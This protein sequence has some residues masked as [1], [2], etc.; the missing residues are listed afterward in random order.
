MLLVGAIAIYLGDFIMRARSITVTAYFETVQGLPAGAEV[1]FAGVKIGRVTAVTLGDNPDFPKQ[2]AAVRMAIY[3]DA[4]VY[5]NDNFVIQQGALLGDKY[6]EVQRTDLK[7]GQQRTQ[8]QNNGTIAGGESQGIEQL[9]EQA[10]ALVTEA[11]SALAAMQAVFITDFNV[12]AMKSIITNVLGATAKADL[13]ATQAMRLTEMLTRQ[14]QQSTPDV[15]RLLS[16]FARASE[17]VASTSEMVR[18]FLV[19]S[20]V[21][22][23]VTIASGNMRQISQDM[24]KISDNMVQL[25]G[26]PEARGKLQMALDNLAESSGHLAKISAEA[27]KLLTD[28]S[29]SEDVRAALCSLRQA[30]ANIASISDTYQKLLTDPGFT[31]DLRG[32]MTA[33]RQ[34]AEAGARTLE[35]ADT[36]L[37]R[38]ERSMA[39]IS[40]AAQSIVPSRVTARASIEST[41]RTIFDADVQY[42]RDPN[43][44]WRIGIRD[45]GHENRLD[46]QRSEP[47]GKRDRVRAGFF[48]GQLGVGYDYAPGQPFNVETELW[49]PRDLHLDVRGAYEFHPQTEV[50]FGVSDVTDEADPFVGV[51]YR[52]SGGR[53]AP[54]DA[55]RPEPKEPAATGGGN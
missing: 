2:P 43:R 42:G 44:F 4:T 34:A 25:L 1:R 26:T 38:I 30:A 10:K 27:E 16:N 32:T 18:K 49:D 55:R 17:S 15:Q 46:L 53:S 33:A 40:G 37:A 14:V 54:R 24:T 21:P 36:Q 39:R 5:A 13:L 52:F 47:L 11:R 23:D 12:Q 20:P 51:R 35:K 6:V 3:R 19:E 31:Q 29:V 7:P 45:V 8:L 28:G 41:G 50:L 9:T 22:R 48:A